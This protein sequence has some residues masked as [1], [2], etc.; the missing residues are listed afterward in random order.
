MGWTISKEFQGGRSPI[1][2]FTAKHTNKGNGGRETVVGQ[3]IHGVTSKKL[4]LVC[5][6]C[7]CVW[8]A[9]S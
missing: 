1:N 2:V 6:S 9:M 5:V 8:S 7:V 4:D 3:A